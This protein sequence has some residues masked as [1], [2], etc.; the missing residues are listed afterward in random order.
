MIMYVS[1]QIISNISI[2]LDYCLELKPAD[3]KGPLNWTFLND[4]KRTPQLLKRTRP[5]TIPLRSNEEINGS[6]SSK[7]LVLTSPEHGSRRAACCL[8]VRI[9]NRAD[10]RLRTL[11]E[12]NKA[13]TWLSQPN[14][15]HFSQL[16]RACPVRLSVDIVRQFAKFSTQLYR[17]SILDFARFMFLVLV[18]LFSLLPYCDDGRYSGCRLGVTGCASSVSAKGHVMCQEHA[19]HF[20]IVV[21]RFL[22][23]QKKTCIQLVGNLL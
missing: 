13:L 9:G 7:G 18:R 16:L 15:S 1:Q 14:F 6:E 11:C 5:F 10:R 19:S 8:S 20:I 4:P 17:V 2:I 22:Q 3:L 23:K 12:A 21:S